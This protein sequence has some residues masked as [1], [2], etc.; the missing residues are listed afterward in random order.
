MAAACGLAGAVAGPE[1]ARLTLRSAGPVLSE[2]LAGNLMPG[3]TRSGCLEVAHASGGPVN[4]G[5]Y[6]SRMV[7]GLA[8]HLRLV[9]DRGRPTGAS[10]SCSGFAPEAT[11]YDGTLA[12]LPR[13]ARSAVPDSLALAPGDATAYRFSLTLA[14]H[15]QARGGRVDWDFGFAAESVDGDGAGTERS[16]PAPTTPAPVTPAPVAPAPVAPTPPPERVTSTQCRSLVL[17]GG[18]RGLRKVLRLGSSQPTQVVARVRGGRLILT[19]GGAKQHRRRGAG[20]WLGVTYTLDDGTQLRVRRVPFRV[21]LKPARLRTGRIAIRVTVA[22]K[23]Y[24]LRAG[25]FVLDV[26]AGPGAA[27]GSCVLR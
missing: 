22:S 1:S 13:E 21:V 4:V 12:D 2:H 9:V 3:S 19:A 10:G 23:R 20:R 18:R 11:L 27:A 15:V 14:D 26:E 8:S 7:G 17:S 5:V 24:A 25:T 6:A 16:V